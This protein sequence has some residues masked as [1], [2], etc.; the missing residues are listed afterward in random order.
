MARLCHKFD[1]FYETRRQLLVRPIESLILR[2]IQLMCN[3]RDMSGS[4]IL[5]KPCVSF[6]M[7]FTKYT[8]I[9]FILVVCSTNNNTGCYRSYD[10]IGGRKEGR[11]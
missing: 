5:R 2:S 7:T 6:V 3:L 1:F 9:L 8:G 11:I 4:F 10:Y